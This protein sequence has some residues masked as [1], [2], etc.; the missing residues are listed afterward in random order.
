[1]MFLAA[2]R[3]VMSYETFQ[4]PF[5]LNNVCAV[6]DAQGFYINAGYLEI[7]LPRELTVWSE[8]GCFHQTYK[9]SFDLNDLPEDSKKKVLFQSRKIHGFPFTVDGEVDETAI[10][11]FETDL[12]NL[13]NIFKTDDKN[14]FA[15][16][17]HYLAHRLNVL[18][19]HSLYLFH[20][21]V[22]SLTELDKLYNT[23]FCCSLHTLKKPGITFQCSHRIAKNCFRW[24][25]ENT[26][27]NG[28]KPIF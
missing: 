27:V 3:R 26:I 8:K 28:Y 20:W 1:M 11:K 24:V 5:Q 18:G 10:E 12:V 14:C 15:V 19:I 21:S 6:I 16:M 7:F 2:K 9:T 23:Q 25:S 13:Y 22:P 17:N 4:S